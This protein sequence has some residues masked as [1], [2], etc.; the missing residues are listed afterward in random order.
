MI[1][2]LYNRT[3]YTILDAKKR[4]ISIK[5]SRSSEGNRERKG[6][7]IRTEGRGCKV[8][9]ERTRIRIRTCKRNLFQS[10][11]ST[12]HTKESSIVIGSNKNMLHPFFSK[13]VQTY[14]ILDCM[15]VAP[16]MLSLLPFIWR[17]KLT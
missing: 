15:I 5:C 2:D 13:L 17:N 3:Y 1:I 4:R 7:K 8:Y 16:Y 9:F 14:L 12:T 10:K 6:T 11:W